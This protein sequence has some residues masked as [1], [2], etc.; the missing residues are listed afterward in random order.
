MSLLYLTQQGTRLHK[1]H[2][3][4]V[5]AKTDQ[6]SVEIPI[7]EV[8]HVFVFGNVQLTT[9][10]IASCLSHQIPVMFLSQMGNYRGHL[11]S[12]E[13]GDHRV[14]KVQLQRFESPEFQYAMAKA[15]VRGKLWNS[16][17]LLLKHNRRRDLEAVEA[18]IDGINQDLL[19]IDAINDDL[20]VLRGYEGTAAARYFPAF[21]QLITNPDFE[22]THRN[23][24]PPTDPVN[25]LLSFGYTLLFNNVFSLIRAEGLDPYLG[26]LHRSDRREAQLA[27]DLMEE[28]RSPIVDTLVLSVINQQVLDPDDF[29]PPNDKGGVYLRDDARRRFLQA[30]EQRMMQTVGHGDAA[31]PIPYRQVIQFQIRRYKQSL[32]NDVAYETFRR[33]T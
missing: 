7:R 22:L 17:Q 31:D 13:G 6:A 28:F 20:N 21:G 4:F 11:W 10:A 14:E 9:S 30:F 27:F 12:A 23:R 29:Q 26:N 1:D 15:I 2:G 3:R 5:V 19:A 16:K 18:A 24:R 32:V 25:S 8:E 33:V